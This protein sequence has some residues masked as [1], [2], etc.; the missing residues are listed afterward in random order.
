VQ[1]LDDAVDVGELRDE[2]ARG[3]LRQVHAIVLISIGSIRRVI[4]D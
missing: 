2:V 1:R 4:L 3:A